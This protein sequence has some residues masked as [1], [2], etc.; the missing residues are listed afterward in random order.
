M[1]ERDHP[2]ESRPVGRS[3]QPRRPDPTCKRAG[4][5]PSLQTLAYLV[6]MKERFARH[7]GLTLEAFHQ[8]LI[9]V[10]NEAQAAYQ[11][12]RAAKA[13]KEGT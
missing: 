4:S 6:L 2:K 12:Q 1:E 13:Q 7:P 10:Y 3:D 5:P 9:G 11:V 8:E